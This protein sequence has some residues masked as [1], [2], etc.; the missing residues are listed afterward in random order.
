MLA[1]YEFHAVVEAELHE[2]TVL[3]PLGTRKQQIL[4]QILQELIERHSTEQKESGRKTR[5]RKSHKN[6]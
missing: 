1:S 2:Q 3:A 5:E 4:K 6:D